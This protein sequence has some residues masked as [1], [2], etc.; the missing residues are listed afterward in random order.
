MKKIL[1]TI[2]LVCLFTL[3]AITALAYT[4]NSNSF[5]FHSEGCRA[6]QKIRADHRIHFDTRDEA[7]DAGYKPCGICKP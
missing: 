2:L 7:I 1:S 6:E 5:K 4:G 3:T